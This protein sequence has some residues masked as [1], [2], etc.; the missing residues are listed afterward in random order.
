MTAKTKIE[1]NNNNQNKKTL[2]TQK[3]AFY[4]KK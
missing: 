2:Y 1:K 4:A 3:T